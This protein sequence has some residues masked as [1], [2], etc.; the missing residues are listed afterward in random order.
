MKWSF[1]IQQKFKTAIILGGMMCMIV[2]ATL[3]SRMNM[4]GIDK[5]FS[6]IYQDRLIPA[7]NIIYLTENLYGKRL[8]LEKFLL[9][10][11]MCNSEEIAAGLS[12]HNNHID[13]LIKAFEKT[14]LVDQEAKSLGAFK[15]RVAEYALLEKVIINLYASGHVAAG[16]ELFEGAGARTFQSTIHNLNELTSIQ[17]RVGQELMKETK[18]DMASFSLI[19]FLQ[20]ALAIIIGLIVIV[21]VQNSTIISKSKASKDSGGYYN[22][23]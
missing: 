23:N 21:L 2:A 4:Q 17:S 7:T 22:L 12:S 6:S 3:I 14:Y 18:S 13:S 15:N 10:D 1:V 11:E 20:I 9:S 5:S 19:S 16:K 8:S